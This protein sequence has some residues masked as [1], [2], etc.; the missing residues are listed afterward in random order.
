MLEKFLATKTNQLNNKKKL[1]QISERVA[2]FLERRGIL[3]RDEGSSYLTLDGLEE[4][5]L[6]DIHTHSV[7]YRVAIGPQKGHKVFTLQTIPPQPEPASDNARVAKLNG[8]SLHAGVAA[9]AHQRKKLERLCRYTARPAIAEKR[10]S[11]TSTGKVRYELKTP[12]RNGTTHVIFEPLDFLARLAALVPKPRV[13]LTRF[14]GVFAPNS[15]HRALI[16]PAGRGGGSK[17]ANK[18][19]DDRSFTERHMAIANEPTASKRTRGLDLMKEKSAILKR[20]SEN[21]KANFDQLT[22]VAKKAVDVLDYGSLS[23]VEE[24]DL[25]AIIAMEGMISHARNCDIHEYLSFTTRLDAICYGACID[26]SN[27]PMDPE[28][29]GEAFK[30]AIPPVKM[31]ATELLIT[32]RKFNCNVFHNLEKVLSEANRVLIDSNILPD[33]DM[34]ARSRAEQQNKRS[35]R[36]KKIDPLPPNLLV[37]TITSNSYQLCSS[38]C[39]KPLAL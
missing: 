19:G 18:E 7:T 16:T 37:W 32:Y 9:H 12:F 33:L 29:I 20:F 35:A 28:Q 8:F 36:P 39:T 21:I 38:C 5:P 2:R 6:L 25:E 26:E 10:L 17:Q 23:L 34:A 14:H 4:D 22:G 15:K 1:H 11:M 30:E 13:N 31:T 3:E 27:N 24:D